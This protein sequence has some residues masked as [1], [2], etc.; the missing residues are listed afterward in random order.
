MKSDSTIKRELKR[1]KAM[2]DNPCLDEAARRVAYIKHEVIRWAREDV[3]DWPNP[4]D[5]VASDANFIL[6]GVQTK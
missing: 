6:N 3:V 2:S 1:L 4:S 5:E